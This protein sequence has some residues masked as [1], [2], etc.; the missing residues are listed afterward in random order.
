MINING[1]KI[2]EEPRQPCV[3]FR[4]NGKLMFIFML[5]CPFA[6]LIFVVIAGIFKDFRASTATGCG[7][8][9]IKYH[10]R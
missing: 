8:C 10:K 7:V 6:A 3:V 9:K 4:L 1:I 2:S 5:A